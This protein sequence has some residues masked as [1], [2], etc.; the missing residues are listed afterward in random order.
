MLQAAKVDEFQA[1]RRNNYRR[2]SALT[3]SRRDFDEQDVKSYWGGS[4]GSVRGTCSV[5]PPVRGHEC[6]RHFDGFSGD[7]AGIV[8]TATAGR[9]N[10]AMSLE[11]QPNFAGIGV[12]IALTVLASVV[13]AVRNSNA[14]P[15]PLGRHW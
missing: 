10:G 8:P 5:V 12:V 6:D 2:R 7:T 11:F 15:G 9:E 13:V 3:G 4:G 1:Q 14:S